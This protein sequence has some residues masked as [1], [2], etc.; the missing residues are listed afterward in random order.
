M[1]SASA[2]VRSHLRTG[3]SL[4]D[5]FHLMVSPRT[6]AAAAFTFY[7]F[8]TGIVRFALLVGLIAMGLGHAFFWLGLPILALTME[9]WILGARVERRVIAFAFGV[10]IPLPYRP[11]PAIPVTT[12]RGAI[13]RVRTVVTDPA[14]WRDLAYH[15]LLFPVG[16]IE[17]VVAIVVIT[18]PFGLVA[19][20]FVPGAEGPGIL[21]GALPAALLAI[22]IGIPMLLLMPYVLNGIA[23]VHVALAQALLAPT[24]NATLAA[25][26]DELTASR[27]RAVDAALAE[28]RRIERDLHDGAQQR[29]VALAMDL[30]MARIKMDSDPESARALVDRAHQEA[31]AAI[32]DI[33]NL[34]RG[35]H[36]AVLTDRGLDAAISALAGRCP[37]P[38]AVIVDLDERPTEAVESA[39]YFVVAEALTNVAKHSIAT[40]AMVHIRREGERLLVDIVDNGVG[41]AD[42]TGGSGL[43]GLADRVAALDGRLMVDSPPGGPTRVRA[44]LPCVS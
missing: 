34:V 23:S 29:L 44:E 24:R 25:R 40:E 35:I 13:A 30:G 20:I 14:T 22:V 41:G 38:V 18:L 37:V 32:A 26:V 12:P 27:S 5:P 6:W 10:A 17:F 19:R 16:L 42:P 33:R 1:T 3:G 31:K 4:P 36:P 9:L 8:T 7:A 21:H 11:R 2:A 15:L 43:A 39:A 28:R